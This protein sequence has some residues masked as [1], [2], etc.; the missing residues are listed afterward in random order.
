[1]RAACV[2]MEK[3]RNHANHAGRKPRVDAPASRISGTGK[4]IWTI[5]SLHLDIDLNILIKHF[6]KMIKE[7]LLRVLRGGVMRAALKL[8]L[9][10]HFRA[11]RSL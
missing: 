5:S 1:M 7:F 6:L 3:E 2:L 11:T 4:S 10:P 8:L 9:R